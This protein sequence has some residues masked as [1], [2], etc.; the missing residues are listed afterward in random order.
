MLLSLRVEFHR[1]LIQ[2]WFK[3]VLRNLFNPYRT[4]SKEFFDIPFWI[5]LWKSISQTP[6]TA[7]ILIDNDMFKFCCIVYLGLKFIAI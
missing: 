4:N 1:T 2:N 5:E 7:K 6:N 3:T